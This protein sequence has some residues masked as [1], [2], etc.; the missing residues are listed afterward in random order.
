MISVIVYGRN[1]SRGYGMQKRVAISLNTI[2]EVLSAP[3]SEIIFVDYNTP[4]H[5]PTLPELIRDML[6][7]K[8]RIRT[9]VLRVRSHVHARFAPYSPL[10][11]LEAIARNVA[12]RRSRPQ[13]RWILSTNT[14]TIL[15]MPNGRSLCE[16]ANGLTGVHYGAPRFEL[17]ERL[18]EALDRLDPAGTMATVNDWGVRARLNEVVRGQG[19]VQ[20]DNPGDFQLVRRSALFAIDGF[21]EEALLGWHVD[22][23]LTHRLQLRHGP[24]GDLSRELKLYHC[25]HARQSTATHA[26]DRIE[27]DVQR[28]VHQVTEPEIIRQRDAWGCIDD[29][30]GEVDLRQ[31]TTLALLDAI[32]DT[33]APLG[34]EVLATSYAS[35]SFDSLW[36]DA[37]HVGVY[38]LDLLSTFPRRGTLGYVGCRRDLV[39]ILSGALV[40]LGFTEKLAVAE[41]VAERLG[42][43]GDDRFKVWS[44]SKLT[45]DADAVV[46]EFGLMR[47]EEGGARQPDVP[48]A[49]T[50]TET[51]AL[52]TV[53]RLFQ[54]VVRAEQDRRQASGAGRM[55]ITLN[56]VNSR[57]ETLVNVNLSATPSPFTTR[58]RYGFVL[59]DEASALAATQ[60]AA[61][62]AVQ[63]FE[64]RSWLTALL[65]GGLDTSST[66][67]V[68][69]AQ[70]P[71]IRAMMAAGALPLPPGVTEE[72][73]LAR[74]ADVE[75]PVEG[76]ETL[77]QAEPGQGQDDAALSRGARR[78]DFE[79]PEWLAAARRV[80]PGIPAGR[81]RRDVWMW[82]R[83]QIVRGLMAL[84]GGDRRK[85]ALFVAEHP[86]DVAPALADLF[87]QL[88]LIDVRSLG[89]VEAPVLDRVKAFTN[90]PH[91]FG[92]RMTVVTPEDVRPGA[93]DAIILPHNAAFRHGVCGLGP[94]IGRLRHALAVDGVMAAGGE[95]ASTGV[96]R[97]E[98]PDWSM[99][100]RDGF[101]RVLAENAGL[102]LVSDD[103]TGIQ[104]EDAALI[105]SQADADAGLPVLGVR[106]S[107]EVF[108]PATWFFRAMPYALVSSDIDTVLSDS[109]LGS[110]I[111]TVTISDKSRL[112]AG[113]VLSPSGLGEGH[114]F[115]GPYLRLPAGNYLA[116]IEVTPTAPES[117]PGV[118]RLVAEAALGAEIVV[119]QTLEID[120]V[121]WD[122][123]ALF[124]LAFEVP[125]AW[126]VRGEA[127]PCEIRLWSNGAVAFEVRV[128]TLDRHADAPTA[129]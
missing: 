67:L 3:T 77:R 7:E 22:H 36:Y 71:A 64:A 62:T 88:D 99:A 127:R 85:R 129:F 47:D 56:A 83:A 31:A 73:V 35:V 80:T 6:T 18:W 65:E 112:E 120:S 9:R 104:R 39:N 109:I 108:W 74:L 45:E 10:P 23:N 30:I 79:T 11:V 84:L 89:G 54:T 78:G 4:N 111:D 126:S 59:P 53:A 27:N 15:V 96:R 33:I 81:L 122:R 50:E 94:L 44:D 2:A 14:D 87:S 115:F 57:F 26:H 32:E 110:Q 52:D 97:G 21:D 118:A 49:W 105:G 55:L 16:I 1:D 68:L 125:Q 128:I 124:E 91:L 29:H 82:E 43:V 12:L 5:L 40:M 76:H 34:D 69:A 28:F 106:R 119:Q 17:P 58:L 61:P 98:R 102:L 8:A 107:G 123:P 13:N 90:G 46:F 92:G 25:S 37:G 41:S 103:F 75:A 101:A 93:Y 95:I 63:R 117:P 60:A 70:A 86:D 20:F 100:G 51:H 116:S 48:V 66:R 24:E 72:A 42:V 121:E 38:L 114:V 113:V 19:A